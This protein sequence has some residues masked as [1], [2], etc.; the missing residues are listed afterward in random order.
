M[1]RDGHTHTYY[2]LHAS[3][4]AT[5]EYVKRAIQEGF[6]VYSFTEH[7]PFPENFF[8]HFPY[9]PDKVGELG[10]RGDDLDA[11]IRDMQGLKE[12]YKDKIQLKVG[13]EI[14][15]LPGEDVYLRH[16]LKEY[17]HFLDDSILS[18]HIIEG[19]GGFRC[20]DNDPE[21]FEDGMI[22]FFSSYEK[23]QIAY[24]NVIKEA[25]ASD[26]GEFKPKRIGHLTLCNKFQHYFKQAEIIS[27]KVK[28]KVMDVLYYMKEHNYSLDANMAGLFKEYC[29]EPYPSP[30]IYRAAQ[31]LHIPLIYGS[32]AHAVDQVGRGYDVYLKLIN[33]AG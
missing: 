32:D 13:L 27:D 15:Y 7:L 31:Q 4:E 3:G 18:V 22:N 9:S 24:Y 8:K 2:C 28:E 33:N 25:L 6:D 12:K 23:A 26:L 11:Y 14:D 16:M 20:M 29:R 21:D 5:E 1:K 19:T 10:L 30:W 17:G